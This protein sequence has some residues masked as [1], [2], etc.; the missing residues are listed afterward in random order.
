MFAWACYDTI[1]IQPE[2]YN[3]VIQYQVSEQ[4]AVCV[5]GTLGPYVML[6]TKVSRS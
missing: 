6:S 4:D 1:H 3:S 2:L 5:K